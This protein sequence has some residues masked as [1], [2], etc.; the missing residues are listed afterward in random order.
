MSTSPVNPET[1]QRS[2]PQTPV[3]SL[4]EP[5]IIGIYGVSGCGKSYLLNQLKR[6]LSPETFK[7][8]EG[9]E[10]INSLVPGGLSAFKK[11]KES[12][13][14]AY[15]QL[16][17]NYISQSCSSTGHAGVVAGH[18]MFW[19]EGE[20]TGRIACTQND[21]KVYTHIV[22]LN[23]NPQTIFRRRVDDTERARPLVSAEHL[24]KWQEAE[25]IQLRQLCYENGILFLSI[26][27]ESWLLSRVSTLIRDFQFHTT[28]MNLSRAKDKL[29]NI[30][31]N[32][33]RQLHTML[34]LDA[35][36]TL[37]AEDTGKLFWE[38]A[39]RR[40]PEVANDPLKTIF[41]SKLGYS[42]SA[43]RQAVLLYEESF[44]HN[45]FDHICEGV[46]E[47]V[48]LQPEFISVL[49]RVKE[50]DHVGAIVVTCGLQR[51]WD[52]I[53]QRAGLSG[54][55][56][57]I[58]GGRIAD[59]FIITPEVKASLVSHLQSAYGLHTWAFGDSPLDL[60]MLNR[61]DKAVVI[62][63]E[64]RS[65]SKTMDAALLEA[66]D[67]GLQAHQ[68]LL[69]GN[70]PPRLDTIKL[71]LVDFHDPEFID[72]LFSGP[73]N[74]NSR[75]LHLIHATE[76]RSVKLLMTPMRDA[77]VA[78]YN[79]REAHQNAGWYLAIEFLSELVGVEEY[80]T[81]HV[82]GNKT[83][84]HRLSHEENTLIVPLMRGG[85]P[86]AFGVSRAIPLARFV[87][88]KDPE[89]IKVEHLHK[90]C[91]VVLV[92]SVINNGGTIVGFARHVRKLSGGVRVVVMAGVVQKKSISPGGQVSEYA[93]EAGLE[94]IALRVSDNKYTGSGGTDTGNRLFNTTHI[95]R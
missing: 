36:R 58:G 81:E 34:V 64:E 61:A 94:L 28:N 23:I 88:A 8:Y 55:V 78:G 19:E 22:Y 73:L 84:G 46:A 68:A 14:E 42:Y 50:D 71:P 54:A 29:D 16:S 2:R 32:D 75:E 76:K 74:N 17:I 26:S 51:I 20:E 52:K 90:I 69:P 39:S 49:Q 12:E 83:S 82:Q 10:V 91:N 38:I 5:V 87:H 13:K 35:D 56:K 21:L 80:P 65:R 63:G 85:E 40:N 6:E 79:L 31:A 48:T 11:F 77:V 24:H 67:N 92:D 59:G 57:V 27:P 41:S 47:L 37:V 4:W 66:I 1:S 89:D 62:V 93:R 7:F 30:L 53:L 72:S 95:L 15:R 25:K 60:A 18:F 33:R 45:T 43:F 70:V 44:G 86:M 9:S 3:S